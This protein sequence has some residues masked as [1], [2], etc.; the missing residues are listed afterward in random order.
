MGSGFVIFFGL[1]KI[2]FITIYRAVLALICMLFVL[3]VCGVTN[4]S[5]V[6]APLGCR[7]DMS[8]LDTSILKRELVTQPPGGSLD[9][10]LDLYTA[11]TRKC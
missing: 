4:S 11:S 8:R 1:C 6:L 10:D 3:A 5:L 7:L 2:L 9:W